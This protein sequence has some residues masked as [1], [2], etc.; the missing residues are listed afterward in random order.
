[1]SISSTFYAPI[2]L[3]QSALRSF[4]LITI[5]R[6]NVGAM[7]ARKM[8]MKLT[9]GISSPEAC[10]PPS[11][12]DLHGDSQPLADRLEGRSGI[13]S[14]LNLFRCVIPKPYKNNMNIIRK[15]CYQ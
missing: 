1:M 15:R 3:Y 8:L 14:M 12:E 4:S 13:G 6:K 5:W 9:T 10:G 7:A 11:I 2:F